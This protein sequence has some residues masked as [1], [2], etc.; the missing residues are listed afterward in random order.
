MNTP[1]TYAVSGLTI[2]AGGI[3]ALLLVVV[4]ISLIFDLEMP[5]CLLKFAG[6]FILVATVATALAFL[7]NIYEY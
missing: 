5:D 7:R 1:L 4:A 2:I 6:V 3:L